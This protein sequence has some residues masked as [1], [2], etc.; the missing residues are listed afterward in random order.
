MQWIIDNIA[1]IVVIAILITS[2]FFALRSVIRTQKRGGCSCGGGCSGNCASCSA[3]CK[4]NSQKS[5]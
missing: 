4:K 2:F 3:N 5:E 1:N